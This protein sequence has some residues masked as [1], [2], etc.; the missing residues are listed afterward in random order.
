MEQ[1]RIDRISE[2]SRI[3]R[4][5][6]LTEEELKE[7]AELRAEYIAAVKK[8]LEGQLEGLRY[9]PEKK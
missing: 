6:V 7:R 9:A 2:L 4:E 8:N 5:R 1:S 3:A